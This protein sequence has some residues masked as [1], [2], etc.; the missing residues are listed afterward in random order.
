MGILPSPFETLVSNHSS[1][2]PEPMRNASPIPI[3][4]GSRLVPIEEED[5]TP[6]FVAYG[7]GKV[8][9]P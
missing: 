7:R 8:Q 4:S 5:D 2:T 9:G 3:P 6:S 1:P